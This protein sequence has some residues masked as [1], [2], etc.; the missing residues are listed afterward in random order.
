MKP[1]LRLFKPCL[2]GHEILNLTKDLIF[3]DGVVND[4]NE[5]YIQTKNPFFT[6]KTR[7]N[8]KLNK[9][10]RRARYYHSNPTKYFFV[11]LFFFL[12]ILCKCQP[13]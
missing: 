10:R 8:A 3:K 13:N 4:L 9:H 12:K 6:N 11:L 2:N 7:K 5:I 1:K